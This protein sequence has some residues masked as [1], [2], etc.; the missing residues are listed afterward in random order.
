MSKRSRKLQKSTGFDVQIS[1]LASQLQELRQIRNSASAPFFDSSG[2]VSRLKRICEEREKLSKS[3]LLNWRLNMS[4]SREGTFGQSE[5]KGDI[6]SSGSELEDDVDDL[7]TSYSDIAYMLQSDQHQHRNNHNNHSNPTATSHHHSHP[8]PSQSH[9]NSELIRHVR[10]QSDARLQATFRLLQESIEEAG[11]LRALLEYSMDAEKVE[12]LLQ[13]TSGSGSGGNRRSRNRNDRTSDCGNTS[14]RGGDA[15]RDLKHRA[16]LL[17]Q[18]NLLDQVPFVS[19]FINM[20]TSNFGDLATYHTSDTLFLMRYN[21]SC[22][23]TYHTTPY[24]TIL[25]QLISVRTVLEEERQR[26]VRA[27]RD[28][29]ISVDI[30]N[31]SVY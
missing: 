16:L 4:Q 13:S 31:V 29:A 18:G 1:R 28:L 10:Q 11:N 12:V 30:L 9:S 21:F 19:V 27:E 24:H 20:L 17:E 15:I 5:E 26:R 8:S 7:S 3:G 6:S 2:S 25:V 22:I 14:I 23:T